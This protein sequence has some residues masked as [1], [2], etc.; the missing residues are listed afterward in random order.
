[1]CVCSVCVCVF[2][3][4]AVVRR[5]CVHVE[6]YLCA[7][8]HVQET[9]LYTVAAYC[10]ASYVLGF[11]DR[12]DDNVMVTKDGAST[13]NH[14]CNDTRNHT[15][16]TRFHCTVHSYYCK[17]NHMMRHTLVQYMLAAVDIHA[18]V[19]THAKHYRD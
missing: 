14:T 4:A 2:V 13:R 16:H 12:H 5:F 11:G 19:H 7:C 6:E 9:F 17:R 10:V 3:C 1:M 18:H 8:V 15:C